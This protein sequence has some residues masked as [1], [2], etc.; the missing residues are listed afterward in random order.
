ML[1]AEQPCMHCSLLLIICKIK[2]S[3][4]IFYHDEVFNLDKYLPLL[5]LFIM[6]TVLRFHG[7][8]E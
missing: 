7:N 5:I 6:K 2:Q 8:D 4:I 1:D 3:E